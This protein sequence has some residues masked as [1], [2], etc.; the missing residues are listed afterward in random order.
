M[1]KW[2]IR[3]R[4]AAFERSFDYDLGYAREILDADTG[5]FLKLARALPMTHWRRDV[6]L[7]VAVAVGI[8]GTLAEDCGPCTQLGVTM[9]LRQGVDA[10]TLATILSGDVDR[11]SEP[12]RLGVRFACAVLAHDPVADELREEIVRRWGP[13]ALVSLAYAL[14]GARLY[15]TLKYALGHGKTCQRVVVAGTPVAVARL[16]A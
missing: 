4:I 3:R 16:A 5:A 10:Q 6:P 15:P 1:I 12:V 14:V 11:M 7:E 8:T 9:A 13:R 2:L